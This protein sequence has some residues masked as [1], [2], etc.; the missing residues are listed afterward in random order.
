VACSSGEVTASSVGLAGCFTLLDIPYPVIVKDS[1]WVWYKP[2]KVH[3]ETRRKRVRGGVGVRWPNGAP[4]LM[5]DS[6]DIGPYQAMRSARAAAAGTFRLAVAPGSAV[7]ALQVQGRGAAPKLELIAPDG[8]RYTSPRAAAKI[9]AG[10]E[11]FAQDSRNATTAVDI[12]SPRAGEWTVRPLKGSAIVTIRRANVDPPATILAAVGGSGLHRILGYSYQPDPQHSIRFV[13]QGADYEQELGPAAGQ[14]C[15]ADAGDSSHPLCGRIEFTPD[16]GPRGERRI[17]AIST[18]NGQITSKQLVATYDAP[19]EPKPSEV[20]AMKVERTPSG[21]RIS[22][23]PSHAPMAEARPMV[24]DIDVNLSDGRKLLVVVRSFDHDAT[25]ADVSADVQ[26]KV[27]VAA[28]R[29]DETQG[30]ERTVTLKP[31]D[32]EAT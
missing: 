27:T 29:S 15:P 14:P 23:A 28:V 12:A 7:L 13:E 22:W 4:S 21:L 9:V 31:G 10:K 20:P 19:A 30:N 25:I 26:A 2:W 24:Y 3:T 8:T 6:C 1:D 5:G 17:Y 18:M 11:V 32:S 16:G